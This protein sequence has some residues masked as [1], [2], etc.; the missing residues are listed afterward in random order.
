M[1]RED[2]PEELA[3]ARAAVPVQCAA[4]T[5]A[6]RSR[7]SASV[8]APAS[9]DS[10]PGLAARTAT[11]RG[12]RVKAVVIASR[13]SGW[14]PHEPPMTMSSGSDSA[15]TAAR[16]PLMAWPSVW[17]AAS[18]CGWPPLTAVSRRPASIAVEP[19]S[20]EA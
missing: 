15:T 14:A 17:R 6:R 13:M 20:P 10:A 12:S 19:G 8:L 2:S 16:T 7:S 3:R 11:C 5:M 9:G 4:A 18:A 1:S